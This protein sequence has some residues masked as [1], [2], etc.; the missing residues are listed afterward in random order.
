MELITAIGLIAGFFNTVAFVPQVVKSWRT[1]STKDISLWMFMIISTGTLL[2]LVYGLYLSLLP[3]IL[4][5][6]VALVLELLVLVLKI[7]YK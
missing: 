5:N 4:A 1:K 2:W 6:S 3:V 7:R